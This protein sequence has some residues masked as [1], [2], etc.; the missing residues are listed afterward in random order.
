MRCK[1]DKY[2]E[3]PDY[4][5]YLKGLTE[6]E[7]DEI[8][9]IESQLNVRVREGFTERA[10]M[11]FVTGVLEIRKIEPEATIESVFDLALIRGIDSC[12]ALI[13]GGTQPTKRKTPPKR[14][15]KRSGVRLVT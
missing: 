4:S 1:N 9:R 6:A 12:L 5:E 10:I 7:C 11:A 2:S 3:H 8:V 13:S 14:N 15:T